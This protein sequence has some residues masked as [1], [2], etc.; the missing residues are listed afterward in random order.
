MNKILSS[1]DNQNIK[2]DN[3]I[4]KYLSNISNTNIKNV[5]SQSNDII[6]HNYS[7]EQLTAVYDSLDDV[8]I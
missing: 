3:E 6:S 8:E 7:K 2:S 4:E 1:L 5:K